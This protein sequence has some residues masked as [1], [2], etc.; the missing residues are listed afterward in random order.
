MCVVMPGKGEMGEKV[1]RAKREGWR[2]TNL[3]Q[4]GLSI[5][6]KELVRDLG[7]QS[8]INQADIKTLILPVQSSMPLTAGAA[9]VF[10]EDLLAIGAGA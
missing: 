1:S 8:I 9:L 7:Q 3:T 4:S 5:K 6:I 10:Q 2:R